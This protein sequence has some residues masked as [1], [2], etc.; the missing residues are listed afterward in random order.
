MPNDRRARLPDGD[1]RPVWTP[2]GKEP[3]PDPPGLK[4]EARRLTRVRFLA[5]TRFGSGTGSSRS[6]SREPEALLGGLRRYSPW[7]ACQ[8]SAVRRR[9]CPDDLDDLLRV[10]GQLR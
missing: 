1:Y 7:P 10:V 3:K 6:R 9:G 2:E 4:A 5:T 8:S